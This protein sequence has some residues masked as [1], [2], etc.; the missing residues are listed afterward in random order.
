MYENEREKQNEFRGEDSKKERKGMRKAA[1]KA[2]MYCDFVMRQKFKAHHY[3]GTV[4]QAR[5]DLCF[6]SY[7][8]KK[9]PRLLAAFNNSK[10]LVLMLLQERLLIKLLG[11]KKQKIKK[12]LK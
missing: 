11:I 3:R 4:L 6:A 10:E 5:L 1:V 7:K 12:Q 8:A 2:A 9:K